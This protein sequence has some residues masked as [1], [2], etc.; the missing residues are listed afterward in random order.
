[1]DD[2]MLA[3]RNLHV[4]VG[5]VEILHGID[6]DVKYGE[7][8]VL[9]GPNGSGKSTLLMALM[10]F[11]KYRV[12]R[13]NIIFKGSD[14]TGLSVDERA[15][16]G[17]GISFQ[18]PPVVRGV[19]T[20][21]MVAACLRRDAVGSEVRDMANAAGMLDFLDRDVNHGFSGGEIK[22]SELLQL[23]AQNPEFI[24]LDEPESGVDLV[25]IA[26]IGDLINSLLQKDV[27]IRERSHSGL[28]IT[29]TGHILDYVSARTGYVMIDGRLSCGGDPHEILT[30]I[31]QC[32][33]EECSRC[34]K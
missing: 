1:M 15:R 9:F 28:I 19:K 20:R 17:V 32:G 23:L 10:G 21:D 29:H 31:K 14:I 7:T 30:T 6:L 13:G 11:P 18:R 12:T 3:V 26:L 8:S 22:R 24:L 34:V 2:V 25:N 33:Y 16:M 4:E 5:G 27:R